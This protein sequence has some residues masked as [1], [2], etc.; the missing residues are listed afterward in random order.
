LTVSPFCLLFPACATDLP[1]FAFVWPCVARCGKT[2]TAS[3]LATTVCRQT[4]EFHGIDQQKRQRLSPQISPSRTRIPTFFGQM[5]KGGCQAIGSGVTDGACRHVVKDRLA[6]TSMRWTD[7]GAQSG[8]E[9]RLVG[10]TCEP[11]T[12]TA[13]GTT[14]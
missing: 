4:G 2:Q 10:F 1:H 3:S 7:A 9:R 8:T 12:L 13:N 11:S 6:Q 5:H 14:S